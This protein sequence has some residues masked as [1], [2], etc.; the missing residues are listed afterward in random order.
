MD[1]FVEILLGLTLAG[2]VVLLVWRR[3]LKKKKDNMRKESLSNDECA[4]AVDRHKGIWLDVARLGHCHGRVP[5]F[6]LFQPQTEHMSPMRTFDLLDKASPT[7]NGDKGYSDG[8]EETRIDPG[9]HWMS[10]FFFRLCFFGSR[11]RFV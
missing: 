7:G 9:N 10:L 1:A 5:D 8:S 4:S 6:H 2:I 11:S 3:H